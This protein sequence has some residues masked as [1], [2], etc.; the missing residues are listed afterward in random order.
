ML[1]QT[2]NIIFH[3]GLLLALMVHAAAVEM[4]VR[5]DYP[6][7]VTDV[8]LTGVENEEVAFRPPGRDTGGRAYISFDSLLE[9]GATLYFTFPKEFYEAVDQLKRG[10]V[11]RALPIIRREARPFL[12][13]MEL[14]VLPGNHLP[15]VYSYVDALEAAKMWAEAVEV[16]VSVPLAQAPPAAL[17]RIG[18]LSHKLHK[19]GQTELADQ[20]HAHILTP[21]SYSREHLVQI[22]QLADQWRESGVYGNAYIL[23]RKVELTEGPL[24]T[25][26][27]L[28][29]GYCSFYL[30]EEIA[31]ERLLE[32]LPEVDLNTPD[33]SLRELIRARLRMRVGDYDAAMRSAAV[34]K[35][36]ASPT[37]SWYPE[38][39]FIL[40]SLYDEFAM[41]SASETAHRELSV[42][43]PSSQWAEQSLQ[44]LKN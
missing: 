24:K 43:F 7:K 9:Q 26:A 22:M 36:Y 25:R 32:K 42:L 37:D 16:A 29:V 3:V 30:K 21:T 39:L 11:Q 23:Y 33:Y 41:A 4:P 17:E 10:S 14:S 28:W 20:L 2:A 1:K 35:T 34:G 12:D 8:V 19:A 18:T 15:A 31:P 38:L 6:S 44:I 13:V 40:A 5:L 27:R